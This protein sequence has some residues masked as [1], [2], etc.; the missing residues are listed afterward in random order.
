MTTEQLNVP[1][2]SELRGLL[3]ALR[4]GLE[5]RYGFSP[6]DTV[7]M[8]VLCL[9]EQ[10]QPITYD[11]VLKCIEKHIWPTMTHDNP[12]TYGSKTFAEM[13]TTYDALVKPVIKALNCADPASELLALDRQ[14]NG[15]FATDRN[16]WEE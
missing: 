14:T 1:L 6:T 7:T 2:T 15:R 9:K 16:T 13:S 11:G 8:G 4:L 5:K 3:Q 12:M 10:G